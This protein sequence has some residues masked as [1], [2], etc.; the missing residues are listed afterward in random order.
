MSFYTQC[1]KKNAYPARENG[2]VTGST[3]VNGREN[4]ASCNIGIDFDGII[5]K[6]GGNYEEEEEGGHDKNCNF[7]CFES[8]DISDQEPI[9]PVSD[10]KD[11]D[12]IVKEKED[13]K[14]F[15][16]GINFDATFCQDWGTHQVP[17]SPPLSSPLPLP[18]L[19][20]QPAPLPPGTTEEE[21]QLPPYPC[22]PP[23]P[24][25]SII[26]SPT[27]SPSICE[28]TV[29][30]FALFESDGLS[31]PIISVSDN[32]DEDAIVQGKV[33][34]ATCDIGTDFAIF[35]NNGGHDQEKK[36]DE[37]EKNNDFAFFESNNLP[38]HGPII[39]VPD[40]ADVD[41]IVRVREDIKTCDI[42]TDFG[43]FHIDGGHHQKEEEHKKNKE[44]AI[45]EANNLPE[46]GPIVPALDKYDDPLYALFKFTEISADDNTSKDIVITKVSENIHDDG[47]NS[48]DAS[49]DDGTSEDDDDTSNEDSID[50]TVDVAV[51][52]N[53]NCI[54]IKNSRNPTSQSSTA[55]NKST[56][57][58]S[59]GNRNASNPKSISTDSVSSSS[60]NNHDRSSRQ[61]NIK[62]A[63]IDIGKAGKGIKRVSAKAGTGIVKASAKAGTGIKRVS[64]KA[65]GKAGAG[66]VNI[67]KGINVRRRRALNNINP[68]ATTK[69]D[70][71][72]LADDVKNDSNMRRMRSTISVNDKKF[73]LKL[74]ERM[75]KISTAVLTP[76]ATINKIID[77]DEG[78]DN[79]GFY[80]HVS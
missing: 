30:N 67:V 80:R 8:H 48:D 49:D 7:P 38:D 11:K 28:G 77:P 64:V 34:T 5:Y 20:Q 53:D 15:S 4:R 3:I 60:F 32:D 13:R 33:D 2:T 22:E 40:N 58:N 74:K 6:N 68:T 70:I 51:D 44:F 19:P 24:H 76:K 75:N 57:S 31:V 43:I 54:S 71:R 26:Q 66:V 17:P 79:L 65:G 9:V 59:H 61:V 46:H 78:D 50:V 1:E 25:P 12:A 16:R 14:K 73:K 35:D 18:P 29:N 63:W 27:T 69:R 41:K 62:D 21:I 56:T 42:G 52:D 47:S 39:P 37:D 45:F 72:K 55:V 10:N 23:P 36:E